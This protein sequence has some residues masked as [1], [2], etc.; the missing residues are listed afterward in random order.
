[1]PHRPRCAV[2]GGVGGWRG[3]RF[4]PEFVYS[5]VCFRSVGQPAASPFPS[6]PPRTVL[7]TFRSTR[8]SSGFILDRWKHRPPMMDSIV[9]ASRISHSSTC[10][11]SATCLPSPCDRLSRSRTPAEAPSPWGSH[12]VGDRE[13][14]SRCTTA[15]VRPSTHP[16]ARGVS[17]GIS[18]RGLA[19][20][21]PPGPG[22]RMTTRQVSVASGLRMF[23]SGLD[24]KQ[25]SLDHTSRVLRDHALTDSGRSP[26]SRHA[27]VP[28]TFRSW[29]SRATQIPLPEG[30]PFL[31]GMH[32]GVIHRTRMAHS[33]PTHP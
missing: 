32:P 2:Q 30:S 22:H 4:A 15:W 16:Y 6:A 20:G 10:S 14:P 13:F 25:S 29:V 19:S 18:S 11:P 5:S 23:R 33:G 12:P 28:R 31:K 1:M 17:P 9:S 3:T 8:L 7:A 21:L 27:L 26:L 24:F